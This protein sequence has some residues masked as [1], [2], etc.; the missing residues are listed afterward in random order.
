MFA[1]SERRRLPAWAIPGSAA[2][3]LLLV[4]AVMLLY[5][6]QR[7][8]LRPGPADLALFLGL[9]LLLIIAALLTRLLIQRLAQPATTESEERL[10]QV[11]DW[12]PAVIFVKDLDGRYQLVNRAWEQT[13]GMSRQVA[14]GSKTADVFP[15][16]VAAEMAAVETAVI[17]KQTA[18]EH[19][20]TLDTARDGR[21]T[22]IVV[23][24]P[25]LNRAGEFSGIG[26]I[27][28]DITSMKQA[29][30]E[31]ATV[32]D[33][34]PDA[35]IRF[36]RALRVLLVNPAIEL[37]CGRPPQEWLGKN[38]RDCLEWSGD[39]PPAAG[40][41]DAHDRWLAEV[42]SCF[43][44]GQRRQFDVPA[45][46]RDG[47]D[48]ARD[49]EVRLFPEMDGGIVSTVL[50]LARDVTERRRASEAQGLLRFQLD[51]AER[52]SGL[53]HL[54]ASVA[55]EFNNVLMGISP[56]TELI[57]RQ[58]AG[59]LSLQ[60]ATEHISNAIARG[61]HITQEV[62]RYARP[63][64]P[65]LTTIK[66]NEWLP[67][68]YRSAAALT[69][70]IEFQGNVPEATLYV[71]A[72]GGQL[73][74]VLMNLI[75]NARDAIESSGTISVTVRRPSADE[76]FPFGRVPR[77][78]RY[79]QFIVAD[80]GPG[81]APHELTRI[82]EPL[83]STKK[84][85]TG[86]GPAVAYQIV[87]RHGGYIFAASNPGE[88]TQFHIFIPAAARAD[89]FAAQQTEPARGSGIRIVLLIEDD[90]PV[91]AGISAMLQELDIETRIAP[92]AADG[93]AMLRQARPDAIV[94]D[95]GLPDLD[96]AELFLRLREID[97][98]MPIIVSTGHADQARLGTIVDQ[99][100]VAHLMKPYDSAALIRAF[101]TVGL[102]RKTKSEG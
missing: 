54:A 70:Q 88:G 55:H 13:I 71:T 39:S 69:G 18:I 81:V 19:T 2:L 35:I 50:A 8:S 93:L 45:L 52:L 29:Q 47:N 74:Q 33:S 95:I 4:I 83:Y 21:R 32:I 64:E 30:M 61:R 94:L 49:L 31:L 65:V 84:S 51:Q 62:L 73:E 97:P 7:R 36:D 22:F 20:R 60:K 53:G 24:F 75:L 59:N 101:Q 85:G 58:N 92:T 77:A 23:Y 63:V 15:A 78:E 41:T 14:I 79:V 80:D 98:E 9:L 91:A 67:E 48:P 90:A 86:L 82:F 89:S 102:R 34:T 100:R 3:W 1:A 6:R 76:V 68:L 46:D 25:V 66:I 11:I 72:D 99:P 17:A 38:L 28:T 37:I 10:Q 12:A 40:W 16:H 42:E 87:A 96:G 56:F 26:G 5:D 43:A 44:A 57:R 27:A